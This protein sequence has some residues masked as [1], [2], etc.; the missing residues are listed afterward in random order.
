MHGRVKRW[1]EAVAAAWE[2]L[3]KVC[4]NNEKVCGNKIFQ[5]VIIINCLVTL[6]HGRPSLLTRGGAG[7]G[8]TYSTVHRRYDTP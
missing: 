7:V 1:G 8:R 6:Q 4:E 5:N 2:R 3:Q